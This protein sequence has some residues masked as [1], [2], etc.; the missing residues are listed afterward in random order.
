MMRDGA[1]SSCSK[2]VV[3]GAV[4]GATVGMLLAFSHPAYPDQ[5]VAALATLGASL[6]S[7][8]GWA[9]DRTFG[10]LIVLVSLVC[11]TAVLAGWHLAGWPGA[12]AGA[13]FGLVAGWARF[14]S[15]G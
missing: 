13:V 10:D 9:S 1:L 6:G 15:Q 3:L 11:L 14:R 2:P 8:R 7:R 4:G 5:L 12:F